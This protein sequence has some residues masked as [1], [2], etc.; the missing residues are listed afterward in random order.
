MEK[1][2][3]REKC[4]VME[5][6]KEAMIFSLIPLEDRT[7]GKGLKLHHQRIC[8]ATRRKKKNKT[9]Q[10]IREYFC[11][12]ISRR[13]FPLFLSLKNY[14]LSLTPLGARKMGQINTKSVFLLCESMER[15]IFS[16]SFL[17]ITLYQCGELLCCRTFISWIGDPRGSPADRMPLGDPLVGH[18]ESYLMR[19][20]GM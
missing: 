10:L 7:T 13:C 5:I 16:T 2:S 8:V 9:L 3:A 6:L 11:I 4:N 20:L 18:Q 12:A 19:V 17:I 1:N 15:K 14:C